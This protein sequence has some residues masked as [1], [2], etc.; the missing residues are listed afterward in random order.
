MQ[1][2]R[3]FLADLANFLD[4]VEQGIMNKNMD[5]TDLVQTTNL[6]QCFKMM[7]S[8]LKECETGVPAQDL[9]EIRNRINV[10]R[11]TV[12][13]IGSSGTLKNTDQIYGDMYLIGQNN[14]ERENY[15]RYGA[16][17]GM[18]NEEFDKLIEDWAEDLD[19]SQKGPRRRRLSKPENFQEQIQG[20]IAE[21]ANEMKSK[22]ARYRDI[23]VKDN[24]A[25]LNFTGEQEKQLDTVT[26]ITKESTKLTKSAN[27]SLRQF[28][29]MVVTMIGLTLAILHI[30]I[31]KIF[32]IYKWKTDNFFI[33]VLEIPNFSIL[34]IPRIMNILIF[35]LLS[36][37]LSFCSVT[38]FELDISTKHHDPSAVT[39]SEIKLGSEPEKA[40]STKTVVLYVSMYS[41]GFEKVKDSQK[42]I[43]QV[44]HNFTSDHVKVFYN[45]DVPEAIKVGLLK[46]DSY[47]YDPNYIH[48]R[49][50]LKKGQDWAKVDI[51]EYFDFLEKNQYE[52]L[53][54]K[55]YE[56]GE[57]FESPD[58]EKT[59]QIG[60]KYTPEEVEAFNKLS[61]P[62]EPL[63]PQTIS[64][65]SH[66]FDSHL[67]GMDGAF[68]SSPV[69][70]EEQSSPQKKKSSFLTTSLS[71]P[72]VLLLCILFD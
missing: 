8:M 21:L 65:P 12:E 35:V 5:L 40:T 47:V 7:D 13:M 20:E 33:P 66:H 48:A 71:L 36:L 55:D 29:I 43:W 37:K 67:R 25:L 1:G 28:I 14:S 3:A 39:T 23:I 6:N 72:I 44:E 17:L 54:D 30:F 11:E 62:E 4:F 50:Y 46:K 19:T 53:V 42:V 34:Q 61:D 70:I 2:N 32:K 58:P 26:H 51:Q 64:T 59:I 45:G 31:L 24:K 15:E 38:V 57:K 18:T 10:A 56:K 52:N 49:F 41:D 63:E 27:L 60:R 22:V 9:S 69:P 68:E 16:N